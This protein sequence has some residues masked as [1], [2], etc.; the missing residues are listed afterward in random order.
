MMQACSE[1]V[2]PMSSSEESSMFPTYDFNYSS[3]QE[4]RLKDYGVKPRPKWITAEFGGH[5]IHVALKK[6]GSNIIFSNGLL[7]PWR[8]GSVLQ[9]ISE[10]VVSLV[11]EE[12]KEF[13]IS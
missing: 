1:M 8:G 12:G 2:M 9:N 7:D 10:S 6:Y 13:G 3:F 4:K 11:T 5:D